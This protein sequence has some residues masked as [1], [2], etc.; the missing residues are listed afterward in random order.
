MANRVDEVMRQQRRSRN[1]VLRDALLRYIE[2][3]EWQQL[4]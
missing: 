3:C 1:E 4:L 2:E